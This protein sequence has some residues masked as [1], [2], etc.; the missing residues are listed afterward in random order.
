MIKLPSIS[1]S[2]ATQCKVTVLPG[3]RFHFKFT[4]SETSCVQMSCLS[5]IPDTSSEPGVSSVCVLPVQALQRPARSLLPQAWQASYHSCGPS[6]HSRGHN[7]P[8]SL[9]S[10][11]HQG[12]LFQTHAF[13]TF[14]QLTF[15][16]ECSFFMFLCFEVRKTFGGCGMFLFNPYTTADCSTLAAKPLLGVVNAGVWI[17]RWT[18][19]LLLSPWQQSL[20]KSWAV[21]IWTAEHSIGKL[22]SKHF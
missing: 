3:W 5:C 20:V 6:H 16:S 7:N 9:F 10:H 21:L 8:M 1:V 12:D 14:P 18:A 2:P 11:N 19:P 4:V 13:I 15:G 17:F 22:S